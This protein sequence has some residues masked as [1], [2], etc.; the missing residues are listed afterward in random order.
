MKEK[1]PYC[2]ILPTHAVVASAKYRT[3]NHNALVSRTNDI[4]HISMA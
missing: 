2:A 3:Y 4:Q 1:I